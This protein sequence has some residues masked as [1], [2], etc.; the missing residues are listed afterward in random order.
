[1]AKAEIFE[2]LFYGIEGRLKQS[3]G[4]FYNIAVFFFIDLSI[5]MWKTF[6][7]GYKVS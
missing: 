1:M 2:I 3:P 6:L 5:K 4:I 7:K